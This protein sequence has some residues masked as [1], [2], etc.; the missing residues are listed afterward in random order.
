MSVSVYT[1]LMTKDT[2]ESQHTQPCTV[3]PCCTITLVHS[4]LC[5]ESDLLKKQHS[6]IERENKAH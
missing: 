5:Q 4:D 1:E 6:H 3:P 2:E